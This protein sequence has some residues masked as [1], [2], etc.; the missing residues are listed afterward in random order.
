MVVIQILVIG[1]VSFYNLTNLIPPVPVQGMI[2]HLLEE[3]WGKL[4]D[5]IQEK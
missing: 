1:I 2:E 4:S 5:N 3:K